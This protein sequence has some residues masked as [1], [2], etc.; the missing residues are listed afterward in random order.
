MFR[1]IDDFLSDRFYQLLVNHSPDAGPLGVARA[2]ILASAAADVVMFAVEPPYRFASLAF[3]ASIY[4]VIYVAAD[5]PRIK[6]GLRNPRR[7]EAP[8]LFVRLAVAAVF[9]GGALVLPSHFSIGHAAIVVS[10]L[11]LASSLY[12]SSCDKL[13]PSPRHASWLFDL[14]AGARTYMDNKLV[15]LRLLVCGGRNYTDQAAAF[16]ALDNY[17]RRGVSMVIVGGA[18]GADSLAAR[19]RGVPVC[20]YLTDWA[21]EGRAAGPLRNQRM[22]DDGKPTP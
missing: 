1:E 16:V 12:A 2:C 4:F 3:D 19:A 10:W 13:P 15:H 22:L 11:F 6:R 21:K 8:A 18:R 9:T 14:F 7:I 17:A 20:E 5:K